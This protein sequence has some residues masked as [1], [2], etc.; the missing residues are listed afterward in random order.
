MEEIGKV[1]AVERDMATVR[2]VRHDQCGKCGACGMGASPSIDF[3]VDNKIKAQP[4]QDVVVTL[5]DY[6]LFKAAFL[7]Y[8]IPLIMLVLGYLLGEQVAKIYQ[9]NETELF[10][11]ITGLILLALS[12]V[13]LHYF[14]RRIDRTCYLPR[15][16]A[17]VN[18]S[19][20]NSSTIPEELPPST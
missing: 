2:L 17:V 8:T 13:G 16:T 9:Y 18:P 19:E 7:V 12:F 5:S 3:T 1:I 6:S 4:G 10:G 14:V 15:L 11:V 20:D